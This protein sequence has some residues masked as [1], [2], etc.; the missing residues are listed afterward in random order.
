MTKSIIIVEDDLFIADGLKTVLYNEGYDAAV[1][2]TLS[3]TREKLKTIIPSLILL[4]VILPDGNGFDLCIELRKQ[5]TFPIIFLT[6]CD[7]E[8]NIV[9][10]LDCGG[11]DYITK[12]FRLKELLSRINAALRRIEPLEKDYI[13]IGGLLINNKKHIVSNDKGV[14]PLTPT[15]FNILYILIKNKSK[16]V[17]R[18]QLLDQIW[19]YNG[20]FIEDNTLSVHISRLREK[21]GSKSNFIATIRGAG[22]IFDINT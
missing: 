11:D 18:Q 20:E 9:R 5:Y 12:P 3:D 19:D 6:C 4:D 1:C 8:I 22:Y 15:E 13:S 14:I 2:K 21:L 16:A 17:D 7:E 10:G